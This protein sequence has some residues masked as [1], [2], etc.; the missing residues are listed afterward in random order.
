MIPMKAARRFI[1]FTVLLLAG[2]TCH[3]DDG[4][5]RVIESPGK[6]ISIRQECE[7]NFKETLLCADKELKP[8]ALEKGAFPWPSVYNFAPN[9]KS[10]PRIQKTGSGENLVM[11]YLIGKDG[12][13]E[14]VSGFNDELWQVANGVSPI[15]KKDLFH[16]GVARASWPADSSALHLVVR[17][18]DSEDSGAGIELPIIYDLKTR[19]FRHEPGRVVPTKS[20][21]KQ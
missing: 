15:K 10:V 18:S 12:R 14:L 21:S 8:V 3:A 7:G 9:E 4:K 2:Q 11:L 16:T 17:G 1:M 6:T 20:S 19:S 5:T 13:V